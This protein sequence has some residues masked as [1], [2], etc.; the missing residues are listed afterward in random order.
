MLY[1]RVFLTYLL[2]LDRPASLQ[3]LRC[4]SKIVLGSQ[5]HST[6][7]RIYMQLYYCHS[8]ENLAETGNLLAFELFCQVQVILNS[9]LRNSHDL[10]IWPIQRRFRYYAETY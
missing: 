4:I 9:F 3:N 5:N 10:K 8:D 6:L 2:E 1:F 7:D